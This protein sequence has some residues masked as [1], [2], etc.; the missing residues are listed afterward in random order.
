MTQIVFTS[1]LLTEQ[2]KEFA[3]QAH[4]DHFFP[5]GRPYFSHL[6][7]VSELS[8]Q[9]FVNDSS[10]DEGTLCCLSYLHDIIEDTVV[11]QENIV[12]L[13]G[14]DIAD[15]VSALTKNKNLPK[16]EQIHHSLQRILVQPKEVWAV[17]L[18][19]RIANLQQTL[20]LI[21]QK[22]DQSYKEYYRDESILILQMLGDSSPYLSHKLSTLISIYNRI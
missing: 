14:N 13:F 3:F 10:L 2:A 1:Q 6:E 8:K 19:D 7:T 9:S 20:F 22:W 5:D 18:S 21:D 15:G 4:K 16:Q 11:T 17:K 12:H